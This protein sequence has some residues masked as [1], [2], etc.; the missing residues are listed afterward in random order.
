[1]PSWSTGK[2]RRAVARLVLESAEAFVALLCLLSSTAYL[3][4]APQPGSVDAVMPG[5]VRVAWG[6]YLLLGGA[7]V[8][9][10]LVTGRRRLEKAGLWLLA[11]PALAYAAA[12]LAYGRA[13]AAFASGLT[14]AFALSF[15]VR[16]TDR[17]QAWAHRAVLEREHPGAGR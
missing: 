13:P 9:A 4:G 14:T 10:G 12:A 11:G 15:A 5:P 3:A 8:L 2:A 16:A 1:M 17:V 6:V 7:G